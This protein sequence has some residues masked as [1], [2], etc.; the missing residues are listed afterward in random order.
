MKKK[1]KIEIIVD[2]KKEIDK[3]IEDLKVRKK[4]IVYV[5]EDGVEKMIGEMKNGKKMKLKIEEKV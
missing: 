4:E 3:N 2:G 5:E 1:G